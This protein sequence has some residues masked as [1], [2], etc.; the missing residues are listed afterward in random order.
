MMAQ[1]ANGGYKINPRIIL[2][3]NDNEKFSDLEQ[4]IANKK[5]FSEDVV[6]LYDFIVK[7]KYKSL[8]KNPENIKFVK[9]ALYG[10]TNEPMGTSYRSRLSK[11][12]LFLPV[13]LEHHRLRDLLKSKEN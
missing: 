1:I 7:F 2:N 12:N 6:S 3:E 10:A 13:K 11:K 4:F 5:L 9:D 8:F